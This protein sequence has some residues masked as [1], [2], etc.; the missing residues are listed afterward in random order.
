MAG[1]MTTRS[2]PGG[3]LRAGLFVLAISLASVAR[4]AAIPQ[5]ENGIKASSSQTA[6]QQSAASPEKP[7]APGVA[8]APRPGD[9]CI[10][11]NRP[12][13]P[14][15]RAYLIDGQRVAVHAA[16]DER[17]R[18]H[19]DR[20]L[21]HLRPRGGLLGTEPDAQAALTTH[22]LAFG[23]YVL[24]GLIFAGLSGYGAVNRGLRPV[25]WFFLGLAFNVIAYLVLLTRS[26]SHAGAVEETPCGLSKVHVTYAPESCPRCGAPNHPSASACAGCGA[27]LAPRMTSEAAKA[28]LAN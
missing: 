26:K 10:V 18:R 3:R 9:I 21:V 27:K 2:S 14:D 28:G 16:E 25:P 12:V 17:F 4:C 11:C 23:A 5:A 15:D 1:L 7:A 8:V 13:S 24:L 22:W 20:Y 19:S 6:S